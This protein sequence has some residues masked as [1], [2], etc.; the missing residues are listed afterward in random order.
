M[1][2]HVHTV[3]EVGYLAHCKKAQ[4]AFDNRLTEV[5]IARALP[6]VAHTHTLEHRHGGPGEQSAKARAHSARVRSADGAR[7][8]RAQTHDASLCAPQQAG[9]ERVRECAHLLS[10]TS[11]CTRADKSVFVRASGRERD[12]QTEAAR[13][14]SAEREEAWLSRPA[15]RPSE[16][17]SERVSSDVQ[18]R[19]PVRV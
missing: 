3:H 18:W 7:E 1:R 5:V 17:A 4:R 10:C 19:A 15:V 11:G 13:M 14:G 16:R 12:R 2:A 8:T 9:K 6:P